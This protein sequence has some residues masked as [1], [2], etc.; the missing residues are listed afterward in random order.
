MESR[1]ESPASTSDAPAFSD[2]YERARVVV[3]RGAG[4]SP[5]PDPAADADGA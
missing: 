2:A 3:D 4:P 1:S 5:D